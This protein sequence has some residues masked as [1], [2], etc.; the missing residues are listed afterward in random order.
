MLPESERMTGPSEK[1]LHLGLWALLV[2]AAISPAIAG[3]GLASTPCSPP[4]LEHSRDGVRLGFPP[5]VENNGLTFARTNVPVDRKDVRERILKEINYLLMD[6]RSRVAA[7]LARADSLKSVVLPIL[8]KYDVPGEFL[9]LAAIESSYDSRALSSAGAYGYWQ[10]IKA[11]ALCGPPGCAEYD[12]KMNI[13]NWKDERADLVH[14]T[15]AAA[16][17]L[18]WMNRV[19]KVNV[20]G[21][22]ERE[23]LNDWLLAAASYNAGPARVLQRLS[24]FGSDS[25]WDVPLPVETERYVP[26]W[27]ALALISRHREFYGLQVT[28]VQPVVFERVEN[29][30]LQKDLSLQNL[31]KLLDT[32][33]RLV[34]SLNSQIPP[35]KGIF[36]ARSGRRPIDHTINVPKGTRQKFLSQLAAHGYTKK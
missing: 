18:A 10:F 20:N 8:R 13:T 16:K 14:S 5:G 19:K 24:Q 29:I 26:R 34:W 6:R 21:G 31:A 30:R 2:S 36:P 7:W 32:T 12:W 33:P 27:I 15:H 3:V 1:K 17:Y 28:P 22:K 23:G 11:T 25:Y 4:H 35:D 9:Y